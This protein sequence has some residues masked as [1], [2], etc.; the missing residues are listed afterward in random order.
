V[1][2]L[3]AACSGAPGPS[4][5]TATPS[6]G[7]TVGSAPLVFSVSPIDVAEIRWITPLGNLNPPAHALPTD[8]IYFY[9]AHPDRGEQP[10]ARRTPFL[11]PGNGTVLDTFTSASIPDVK[12]F[13]RVNPTM[14]YYVDHLIPDAPLAR[15]TPVTAGQR[16]G[17]TGTAFAID[18]GVVNNGL[19]LG[20][21]NPSRY[22]QGDSLHAD[23][24]LKYFEE[25]LRSTL[26][27]AVQRLG[28]DK[29]GK[30]DFDVAG[31][32]SGNWF[33]QSGPATLAFAYDTYDPSRVR[34]SVTSGFILSGVFAIADG[35]P[36]PREVAVS[37]GKVRYTLSRAITGPT[38]SGGGPLGRM[39]VQL[40]DDQRIRAEIFRMT[41]NADDFTSAARV[42]VR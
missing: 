30:I 14:T 28:D 25:P 19:T 9:F 26:Y 37:A 7:V 18:L 42:F 5:P 3:A 12:V 33:A 21:V 6:T 40:L 41:D 17:T 23:A 13:I 10:A 4:A 20:F 35:E 8:H 27:A 32:L 29:D 1:A 22:A 31:R 11:A 39:L 38:P 16:L 15:G 34:I 24:P 2:L 36:D